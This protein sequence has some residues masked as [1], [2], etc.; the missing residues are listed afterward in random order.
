LH[1]LDHD[2]CV[3]VV[4]EDVTGRMYTSDWKNKCMLGER[5]E[6]MYSGADERQI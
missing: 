1:V 5:K 4:I 2:G 6:Q 3:D